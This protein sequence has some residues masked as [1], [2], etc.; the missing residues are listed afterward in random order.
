MIDFAADLAAIFDGG[1]AEDAIYTPKHGTG[2]AVRVMRGRPDDLSEFGS[3]QIR[4]ATAI[5]I[6]Q[7]ADVQ[8]AAPGDTITIGSDIYVVQG[9]PRRDPRHLRWTIE[10]AQ[11]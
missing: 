6:V 9:A 7:V 2:L 5:F 8:N 4:T 11:A 10:A 3:T 1:L